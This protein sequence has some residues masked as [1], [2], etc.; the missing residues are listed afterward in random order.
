MERGMR[1]INYVG[2]F[3]CFFQD[4]S[5]INGNKKRE[6]L[7]ERINELAMNRTNLEIT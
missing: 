6:Q 5:E 3:F 4:P 2:F 7:E 1:F